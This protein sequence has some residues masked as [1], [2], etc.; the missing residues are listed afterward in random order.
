MPRA[1]PPVTP[2]G[3][4]PTFRRV[5]SRARKA[6]RWLSVTVVLYGES[7]RFRKTRVGLRMAA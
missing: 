4:S 2:V 3:S 6:A 1:T 5:L 7:G